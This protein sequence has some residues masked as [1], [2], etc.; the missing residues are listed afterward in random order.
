MC[1]LLKMVKARQGNTIYR[2]KYFQYFIQQKDLRKIGTRRCNWASW[3]DMKT[4]WLT[5]VKSLMWPEPVKHRDWIPYLVLNLAWTHLM[6]LHSKKLTFL[7]FMEIYFCYLPCPCDVPFKS[8]ME[9][10]E[11]VLFRKIKCEGDMHKPL[12]IAWTWYKGEQGLGVR[13]VAQPHGIPLK[14]LWPSLL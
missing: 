14:P 11:H 3:S 10:Q 5:Y 8:P 13:I 4:I 6:T 9:P 12:W 2:S 7:P 1:T